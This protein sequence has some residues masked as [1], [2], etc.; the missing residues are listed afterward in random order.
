MITRLPPQVLA[1][2]RKRFFEGEYGELASHLG[3]YLMF[4]G[5]AEVHLTTMM[6]AA[7]G[8]T[9][10]DSAEILIRGMDAR[11][12]IERLRQA[13]KKD[14]KKLGPNLNALVEVYLQKC[15]PLRN[16][17][18]HSW[19][20]TEGRSVHFGSMTTIK[21]ATKGGETIDLASVDTV[22]LDDLMSQA[23]WLN[24]LTQDLAAAM[25]H[26]SKTGVFEVTEPKSDLPKL[27]GS[28]DATVSSKQ[29]KRARRSKGKKV[30]KRVAASK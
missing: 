29:Q 4:F 3:T 9:D 24:T 17:I 16:K 10:F 30:R 26:Y 8:I 11:V 28:S 25:H 27:E 14:D 13:V 19:P 22:H 12:K 7:A 1:A 23:M 2:L 15:L 20:L 6:A 18:A 21:K 5:T